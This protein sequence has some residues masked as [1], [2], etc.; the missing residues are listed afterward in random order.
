MGMRLLG[1]RVEG[2]CYLCL[3]ALCELLVPGLGYGDWGL[4]LLV[5]G[6]GSGVFGFQVAVFGFR[7][8]VSCLG[9]RI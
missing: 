9:L 5:S 1:L 7:V 2:V 6:L 3:P 4:G 8:S